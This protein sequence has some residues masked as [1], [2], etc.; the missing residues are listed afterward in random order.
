MNLGECDG[1]WFFGLDFSY[2]NR[3]CTLCLVK[4]L[5]RIR[6]PA[7]LYFSNWV[8]G[9]VCL[10]RV[11]KIFQFTSRMTL[12]LSVHLYRKLNSIKNDTFGNKYQIVL[13]PFYLLSTIC[14]LWTS[15]NGLVYLYWTNRHRLPFAS[16]FLI[17]LRFIFFDPSSFVL[18]FSLLTFT[19]MLCIKIYFIKS[20]C[21]FIYISLEFFD[22]RISFF[23]S[24]AF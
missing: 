13:N 12:C 16:S 6:L 3:K 15:C 14:E 4:Y 10:H 19:R 2:A 11:H 20:T 8:V 24:F 22:N 23:S 5:F 7:S 21:E 17:S 18:L 1:C 9:N